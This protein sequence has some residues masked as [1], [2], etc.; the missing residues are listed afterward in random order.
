[1]NNPFA[2]L[3]TEEFIS[4]SDACALSE[5]M[6]RERSRSIKAGEPRWFLDGEP[7][8][9]EEECRS[10]MK[11]YRELQKRVSWFTLTPEEREGVTV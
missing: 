4:L 7:M 11:R 1:M 3:T 5:Q 8:F 10:E 2:S 9:T 6:W